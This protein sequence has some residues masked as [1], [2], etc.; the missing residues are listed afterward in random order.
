MRNNMFE[1][2]PDSYLLKKL[3]DE[4]GRSKKRAMFSSADSD[5]PLGLNSGQGD[6]THSLITTH[7]RIFS[8]FYVCLFVFL[9]NNL[10]LLVKFF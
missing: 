3:S 4:G 8:K 9:L 1:N 7:L 6:A 2:I 10:Y 5:D